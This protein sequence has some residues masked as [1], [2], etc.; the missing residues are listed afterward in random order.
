MPSLQRDGQEHVARGAA[1]GLRRTRASVPGRPGAVEIAGKAGDAHA[2]SADRKH[3]VEPILLLEVDLGLGQPAGRVSVPRSEKMQPRKRIGREPAGGVVISAHGVA[4]DP[5]HVLL[6][7]VPPVARLERDQAQRGER[8]RVGEVAQRYQRPRGECRRRCRVALA[9]QER[10]HRL[11]R[12][13]RASSLVGDSGIG[14]GL[15][16]VER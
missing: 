14:C 2:E 10:R 6:D 11:H 3:H 16:G 4:H 1:G 7:V 8:S 13:Q 5:A 15:D 12:R 9:G